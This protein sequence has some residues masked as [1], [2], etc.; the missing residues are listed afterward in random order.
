VS[1][2]RFERSSVRIALVVLGTEAVMNG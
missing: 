1:P 2:Y